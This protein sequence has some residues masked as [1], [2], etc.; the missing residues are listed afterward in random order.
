[1]SLMGNYG[2]LSAKAVN[3]RCNAAKEEGR[4]Y[5]L[6]MEWWSTRDYSGCGDEFT[7]AFDSREELF[8]GRLYQEVKGVDDMVAYGFKDFFALDGW[9]GTGRGPL[10]DDDYAL[11][12]D[13]QAYLQVREDHLRAI[14][15]Y[16]HQNWM[17][18][19]LRSFFMGT[20][21]PLAD[22]RERGGVL[23]CPHSNEPLPTRDR[24]A[25]RC[26]ADG[27]IFS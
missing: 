12:E 8:G 5:L 19:Q 25:A 18:R 23:Y 22:V 24:I 6:H 7:F 2:H 14:G 3:A 10:S 20:A 16:Q 26:I 13:I 4:K 9:T 27:L 21:D 17:E 15:A 1:M 11:Q